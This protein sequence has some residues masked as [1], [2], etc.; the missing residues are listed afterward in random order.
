MNTINANTIIPEFREADFSAILHNNP[1]GDLGYRKGFPLTF[2]VGLNFGN[3]EGETGAKVMAD[4][5]AL[6]ANVPLKGREFVEKIKGEI[7]K[8][9][10]G[11]MKTE[12][13]FFRIQS[14]REAVS[15]HPN[16]AGVKNQ[17]INA[18]YDDG[19][20]VVNS[21]NARLEYMAK[22]LL[23]KGA[24]TSNGVT[25]DFGIEVKN[26]SKDWFD[27]KN[28]ET[29]NP[30]EDLRTAQKEALARG[31]RYAVAVMDL[32]TFNQFVK[33]PLVV[34]FTASFAQNALGL[35][36]EPTLAQVNTALASQ[37]LPVIEIWES[38]LREEGK[39]GNITTTSGWELGN[40]HLSTTANFGETQ[41]TLSPEAGID[42]G[43]STKTTIDQFI[44]VSVL[45]EA[46]PMRVLTK[47]TAF[48]TPVLNNTK[49]KLILK[50]KLK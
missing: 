25:L 28:A 5:V 35:A 12:R 47:G 36:Q 38:Y 18:I 41:Y 40:I 44:L 2:N 32:A 13:D 30:I 33:S 8:I 37:N 11:R 19:I 26:A 39:D 42:L 45:G 49:Q 9:E 29:F 10:V 6:D 46:N 27:V 48:A 31:F 43:E 24:Y 21:V 14:L 3:L 22:S 1:L 4:V 34:K 7:P 17:L 16:N 50:T 15:R 20:F 23:S